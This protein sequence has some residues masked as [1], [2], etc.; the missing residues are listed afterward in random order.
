MSS[1]KMPGRGVLTAVATYV[2][3]LVLLA[4][5]MA[6]L[7][8]YVYKYPS[9]TFASQYLELGIIAVLAVCLIHSHQRK[10]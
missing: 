3:L 9:V 1:L 8:S 7:P 10:G 6:V 2:S 4:I 5:L